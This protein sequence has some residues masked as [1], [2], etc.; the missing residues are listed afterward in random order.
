MLG[1]TTLSYRIKVLFEIVGKMLMYRT[2][3]KVSTHLNPFKV[4]K[5]PLECNENSQPDGHFI[6]EQIMNPTITSARALGCTNVVGYIGQSMNSRFLWARGETFMH[7]SITA[8]CQD[9][10]EFGMVW[11]R[12]SLLVMI[13][14]GFTP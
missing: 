3:Q 11:E 8:L 9:K 14:L 1:V 10:V 12:A 5:G 7:A 2:P 13:V 4:F 6:G